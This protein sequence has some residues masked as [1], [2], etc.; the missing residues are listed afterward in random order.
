MRSYN[1]FQ[2]EVGTLILQPFNDVNLHARQMQCKK[3]A[4]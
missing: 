3:A 4:C 1:E 2:A